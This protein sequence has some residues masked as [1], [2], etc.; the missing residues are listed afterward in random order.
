M[1]PTWAVPGL[2]LIIATVP[3]ANILQNGKLF[4]TPLYVLPILLIEIKGRFGL[5]FGKMLA[6]SAW[7][8]RNLCSNQRGSSKEFKHQK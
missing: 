2:F 3:N 4:E 5:M 1:A 8:V 6:R 7:D